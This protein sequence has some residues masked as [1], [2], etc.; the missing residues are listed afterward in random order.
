L[1]EDDDPDTV[2]R[3]L[4]YLYTCDYDDGISKLVEA[5]TCSKKEEADGEGQSSPVRTSQA[6]PGIDTAKTVPTESPEEKAAVEVSEGES[7]MKE[8][9]LLN[10]VMVYAIAE[11]YDISELKE[12]AKAKFLSQADTLLSSH[13]F[14]EV[15]KTIY[16]STLSK[17]RGLRDIVSQVCVKQV[18]ELME[19]QAFQGIISDV[20][21]FGIDIL[22]EAL[23]HDDKRLAQVM[24]QK[25]KLKDK[26]EE[27]QVKMLNLESDTNQAKHTLKRVVRVVNEI[28]SCRNCGADFCSHID[29]T[30]PA[31]LQCVKCQVQH[32]VF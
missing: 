27:I 14:P 1:L 22:R 7:N 29:E 10:N 15:V 8:S 18:R 3:M 19:D 24:D 6:T 30:S 20:G 28:E 26:A 23:K 12:L 31:V 13:E 17:D 25:A 4:L 16:T 21:D 32:W 11:R 2:E 5:A 9:L